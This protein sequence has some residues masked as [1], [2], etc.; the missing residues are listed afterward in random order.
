VLI[1]RDGQA[2]PWKPDQG[3]V[4]PAYQAVIAHG[5]VTGAITA[6]LA[7]V[8]AGRGTP[9]DPVRSASVHRRR[10]QHHPVQ[11]AHTDVV[12]HPP[13]KQLQRKRWQHQTVRLSTGAQIHPSGFGGLRVQVRARHKAPTRLH[14]NELDDKVA[15]RNGVQARVR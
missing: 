7:L 1:V 15:Q 8:H 11:L 5:V 14:D 9:I 10:W 6:H 13:Q 12:L 2:H 4:P 3:H